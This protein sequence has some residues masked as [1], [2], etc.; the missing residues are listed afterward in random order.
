MRNCTQDRPVSLRA[1][2]DAQR[3]R[4][5]EH[6]RLVHLAIHRFLR[7]E[8]TGRLGWEY[9]DLRQEGFIALLD[10]VLSHDPTRHGNFA[11]FALSRIRHAVS[12]FAHEYRSAIRIP[13]ITQRRRKKKRRQKQLDKKHPDRHPRVQKLNSDRHSPSWRVSRRLYAESLDSPVESITIGDLIRERILKAASRT[14]QRMR[15]TPGGSSGRKELIETCLNERWTIPDEAARTPIRQL[16]RSLGCSLGRITH[17]EVRFHSLMAEELWS[18][19][20]LEDLRRLA[21]S[22]DAGFRHRLQP[23]EIVQLERSGHAT[24][25]PRL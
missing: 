12:R 16:A 19:P 2:S 9:Q 11:P 25:R 22:C 20:V 1:L 5:A 7:P 24:S 6:F 17:S 3:R 21:R 4:A 13:Y 18:D 14:V 10:A 15:Q 8:S 23:D